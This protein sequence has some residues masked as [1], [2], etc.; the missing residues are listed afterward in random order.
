MEKQQAK[1]GLADDKPARIQKLEEDD[2]FQ[3]FPIKEW[4]QSQV[5]QDDVTMWDDNWDN[6]RVDDEFAKQ[7]RMELSKSSKQSN[8]G[9]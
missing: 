5:D 4:D 6:D 2:E 1:T 7:L 8:L 9:K 3:E